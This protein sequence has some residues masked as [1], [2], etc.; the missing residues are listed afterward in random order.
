MILARN[1]PM[2]PGFDYNIRFFINRGWQHRFISVYNIDI[3]GRRGNS[4]GGFRG[5][6]RGYATSP[7]VVIVISSYRTTAAVGVT[8]VGLVTTRIATITAAVAST[9][10]WAIS[11]TQDFIGIVRMVVIVVF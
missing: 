1:L 5:L 11:G 7:T 6:Q 3:L 10:G 2:F 9:R 4:G 8:R